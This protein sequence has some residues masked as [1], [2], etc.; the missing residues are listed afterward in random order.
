MKLKGKVALVTGGAV[1]VGKAIALG[2][3]LRGCHVAITYRS[4]QRQ[5]L[6]TVRA[7]KKHRIHAMAV[8]VDQRDGNQVRRAVKEILSHLGRIDILVNSASSFYPTPW[9]QVTEAQWNDLLATNLSG[10]WFFSQHVGAVMKRRKSGKII[11]MIDVS[12]YSPWKEH[13]PYSAAK[14]GLLT[15]TLGFAKALAPEVQVNGIAPGPILFPEGMPAQEKE[16]AIRRT[17]L[18]RCGSPKDILEAVL[19]FVEST[20]FVTGVILPVDGGR[21]LS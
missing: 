16:K 18:K 12:V 9:D 4:S 19:F 21:L 15:L 3:A 7:L 8:R 2:L 5:A 14:G 6:S 1:R 13:L 17:L 11:N 10:P 20:D